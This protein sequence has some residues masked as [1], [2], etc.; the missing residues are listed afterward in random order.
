MAMMVSIPLLVAKAAQHLSRMSVV[1]LS[2]ANQTK[3]K[4]ESPQMSRTWKF[5]ISALNERK[6]SLKSAAILK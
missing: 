2:D 3:E 1:P 5:E 4:Q 6:I